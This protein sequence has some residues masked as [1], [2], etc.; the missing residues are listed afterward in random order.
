M[1]EAQVW[2][3]SRSTWSVAKR[4]I[5]MLCCSRNVSAFATWRATQIKKSSCSFG[6]SGAKPAT[7]SRSCMYSC[8]VCMC[9]QNTIAHGKGV[10]TCFPSNL[11]TFSGCISTCTKRSMSS[12]FSCC[13]LRLVNCCMP[14]M[15]CCLPVLWFSCSTSSTFIT[16][17]TALWLDLTTKL[18]VFA[19][20][21]WQVNVEL[22]KSASTSKLDAKL[23]NHASANASP[24]CRAWQNN[25]CCKFVT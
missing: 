5:D 18:L 25:S 4:L 12:K 17:R 8:R 15:P 22:D 9:W 21:G 16:T 2:T 7:N 13:L 20:L 1:S 6:S 11:L 10:A 19:F 23:P 3:L 14:C 24:A